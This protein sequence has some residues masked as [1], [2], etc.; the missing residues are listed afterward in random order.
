[1]KRTRSGALS[2]ILLLT[3][4]SIGAAQVA[5]KTSPPPEPRRE[6]ERAPAREESMPPTGSN[7][8]ISGDEEYKLG[9]G[10][11]IRIRIADA[12]ELSGE[13]QVGYDGTFR[14][15]KPL[16]RILAL[17]KTTEEMEK[18]MT[19]ALRG[20]Y[21]INPE[22]RIAV[23]EYNSRAL[24]VQG[25]VNRPGVF[26][27]TGKPHL[28]QLFTLAGGLAR[29]HGSTAYIIRQA[30]DDEIEEQRRQMLQLK[31]QE[32]NSGERPKLSDSEELAARYKLLTVNINGLYTGRLDQNMFL[33][34]GDI[35]NVPTVDNFF[36]SGSVK[37]PGQF[38]LRDGT[39]LRMAIPM[40]QGMTV[41]ASGK[42]AMIF[43]INPETGVRSQMEVNASDILAGK[44][45]DIPI[46]PNDVIVIPNN[47]WKTWGM[48]VLNMVAS[49]LILTVL[50]RVGY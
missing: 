12:E 36:V 13:Y 10:D 38:V 21:L 42:R 5:P 7:V 34:P 32:N 46:Y 33:E 24:F 9:P 11:R 20:G 40:A 37:A 1:M 45:D 17:G 29:D 39:T 26:Q 44:A 30:K 41:D 28:L 3:L 18:M 49:S 43:R 50:L 16:G 48:P 6:A 2:I 22:V 15:P 4:S 23:T 27:I 47:K 25:S 35:V 14:M 31:E 8:L 19:E